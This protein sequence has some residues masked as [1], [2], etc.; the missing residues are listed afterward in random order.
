MRK[1]SITNTSIFHQ[2][3]NNEG[4]RKGRDPTR[5]TRPRELN[6]PLGIR[7]IYQV[8][9]I[10]YNERVYVQQP[11]RIIFKRLAGKLTSVFPGEKGK[12]LGKRTDY[13]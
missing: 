4:Q 10:V 3:S 11:R 8:L 12:D 9:A 1:V 13:V 5:P 2:S 7:R 6:I